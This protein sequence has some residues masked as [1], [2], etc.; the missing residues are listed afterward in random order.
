M[1]LY[2]VDGEGRE[3]N[4]WGRAVELEGVE[5]VGGWLRWEWVWVGRPPKRQQCK[6]FVVEAVRTCVREIA[7][8][9]ITG[10]REPRRGSR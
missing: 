8:A 10:S 5:W 9:T 2:G 3:E 4:G 6:V 7:A 1:R